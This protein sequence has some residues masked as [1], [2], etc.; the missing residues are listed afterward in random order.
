MIKPTIRRFSAANVTNTDNKQQSNTFA[1]RKQ[2]QATRRLTQLETAHQQSI[3]GQFAT[4]D[5]LSK[6][7]ELRSSLLERRI[8]S[9]KQDLKK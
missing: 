2:E 4:D 5:P 3:K 9:L 7:F 8:A 1:T 6:T